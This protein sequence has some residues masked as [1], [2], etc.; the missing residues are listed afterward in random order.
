M[1]L[2]LF[3]S[4]SHGADCVKIGSMYPEDRVLVAYVPAP[5]DFTIIREEGWYRIP[6]RHMPK[7]LYAE[8][9]AFYF[10]R[11]FGPE[12]WAMSSYGSPFPS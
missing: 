4:V 12:K 6:Q 5:A 8:Y 9:F 2:Y 11:K 1:G 3:W 10:G 7:G